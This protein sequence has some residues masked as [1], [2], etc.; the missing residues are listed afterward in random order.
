MV[1]Q[2]LQQGVMVNSSS[3]NQHQI[4]VGGLDQ[5]RP[6]IPG[7][8]RPPQPHD[9]FD[10]EIN[11]GTSYKFSNTELAVHD[12]DGKIGINASHVH[13]HAFLQLQLKE[14]FEI[15]HR[16]NLQMKD[17]QRE[18]DSLY[19]R[20]RGYLLTQDQ[21]YKDFVRVERNYKA[22]EDSTRE[23]L[24]KFDQLLQEEK[25]KNSK[26]EAALNALSTNNPQAI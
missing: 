16:L 2:L 20:T 4:T 8:F 10:G 3:I 24:R 19:K 9:A 25:D 6:H 15:N 5:N 12:K 14:A 21:L 22:K 11:R 17:Q 18:I 26:I 13:E 23:Q 7:Q 1:E